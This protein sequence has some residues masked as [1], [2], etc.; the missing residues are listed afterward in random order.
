MLF[1]SGLGIV[2]DG[3]AYTAPHVFSWAGSSSHTINV[4]SP[5]GASGIQYVYAGW[6]DAGAQSH[7]V[8]VP[9]T[10][11]T[12][13]ANFNTR[14]LLSL[15]ISPSAAGSITAN[16][17]SADGYYA[18]GSPVSLTAGAF[19]GY[20]FAGWSGSLAGTTNPQSVTM[21]ATRAVTASFAAVSGGLAND[22]IAGATV[23]AALPYNTSQNTRSA[24]SNAS[25]PVHSCT[26]SADSRTVWFRYLPTFNGTLTVNTLGSDYDTVLAV[27][28]GTAAAGTVLGCND[29]AS[30][31]TLT[32][33]LTL[34]VTSGQ[35]ILIEVG[36]YG[37]ASIG[38]TMF[39]NLTGIPNSAVNNDETA[40]AT[41]IATL[42][43][44]FSEDTSAATAGASDPLHSCTASVDGKSVWF[45]YVSTYNGTLRLSTVGSDYDTVLSA[46][47]TTA[48]APNQVACNDDIDSSTRQSSTTFAVLSG[49]TY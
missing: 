19:S 41:A 38:G 28:Q 43:A 25:D 24:T 35:S 6:S 13:T 2:V 7:T 29:D 15:T 14:Y 1:R 33:A 36:G 37:S 16:P 31:F 47:L 20:T 21:S 3:T 40:S 4:T 45:R 18:A 39:L 32:S 34:P 10:G 26:A 8:V 42:P 17:S 11:A 48:T 49:Q 44:V 9:S 23:I 12:Y 46:Y 30:E 5:Q 22:E 27:Y